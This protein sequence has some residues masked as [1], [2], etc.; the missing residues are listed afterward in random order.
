MPAEFSAQ[1]KTLRT[2]FN[3]FIYNLTED[4]AFVSSRADGQTCPAQQ[5]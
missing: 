3:K 2:S 4:L 5:A 1:R